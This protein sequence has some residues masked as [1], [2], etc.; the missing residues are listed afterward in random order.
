VAEHPGD[1][2]STALLTTG[3]GGS[4]NIREA[5]PLL[6]AAV[7]IS[8]DQCRIITPT[9]T[10]RWRWISQLVINAERIPF[11]RRWSWRRYGTMNAAFVVNHQA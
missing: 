6:G 7:E 10:N 1:S 5:R 11:D 3:A 2:V 9:A 8:N 4:G